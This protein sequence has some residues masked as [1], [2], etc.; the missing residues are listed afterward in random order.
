MI[1]LSYVSCATQRFSNDELSN[2]LKKCHHHNN[3]HEISGLLLYNGAGTF[4]QTLEGDAEVVDALYARIKAD[5]RHQ[6][7]NCIH[8]K[9][10]EER[11]FPNWKM[12]YRNLSNVPI[13]SLSGFSDFMQ[14][15]ESDQYLIEN[16]SFA[17]NMLSYFKHK[18]N[19]I[20]L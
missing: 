13:D 19:E 18:S 7:V 9:E 17:Q 12:G 4:L 20:V 1:S 2:L 3:Q 11:D 6:R 15:Q 10:I 14:S 5:S 16:A 8:R